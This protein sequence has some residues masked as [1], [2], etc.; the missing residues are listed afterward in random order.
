MLLEAAD[1]LSASPVL[2]GESFP[3]GKAAGVVV[4][5][6]TLVD[7]AALGVVLREIP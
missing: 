5:S 3:V 7:G 4:T 2:T 1:G 6:A